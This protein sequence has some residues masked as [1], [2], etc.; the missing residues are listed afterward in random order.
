MKLNLDYFGDWV[1]VFNKDI[2]YNSLVK[3]SR[4]YNNKLICTNKINVF[5]A[6]KLC[7]YENCRV[8]FIGQD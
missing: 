3:L 1:K 7:P 5:K 4:E 2:L 6:F 8:V